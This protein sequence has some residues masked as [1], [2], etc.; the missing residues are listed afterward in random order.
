MVPMECRMNKQ[1][2]KRTK[3]HQQKTTLN[4]NKKFSEM[5]KKTRATQI[6]LSVCVC[7]SS[8]A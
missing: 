2:K 7:F 6:T 3:Y 1:T 5:H 4:D 8:L